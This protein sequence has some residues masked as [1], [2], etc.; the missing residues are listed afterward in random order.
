MI[1]NNLV[2]K[3][4]NFEI[5]KNKLTKMSKNKKTRKRGIFEKV[6]RKNFPESDMIED[7]SFIMS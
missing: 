1:L 5:N 3:F 6:E 7:V 2:N 4:F